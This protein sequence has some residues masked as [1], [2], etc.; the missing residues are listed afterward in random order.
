MFF[1]IYLYRIVDLVTL[2]VG[3]LGI[4]SIRS[5]A[6]GA[7]YFCSFCLSILAFGIA[8][9]GVTV[10]ISGFA[11]FLAS[12]TTMSSVPKINYIAEGV[13][14]LLCAVVALCGQF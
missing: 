12:A 2:A 13:W 14:Q 9:A 8:A 3:K 5:M 10:F 4:K 1:N 11:I 7:I 6:F